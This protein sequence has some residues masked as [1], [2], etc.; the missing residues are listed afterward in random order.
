MHLLRHFIEAEWKLPRPDVIISVTGGAQAFDLA[1]VH[2]DMIMRGMMENTRD[3][4]PLFI[5]GGTNSG[6]MKVFFECVYMQ[7]YCV[8]MWCACMGGK[9]QRQ[10]LSGV[11]QHAAKLGCF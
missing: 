11:L 2:K 3:M 5:T 10:K 8:C 6:I 4:K 1:T 7:A 9:A